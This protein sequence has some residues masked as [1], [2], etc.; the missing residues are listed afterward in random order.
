VLDAWLRA[1]MA[2]WDEAVGV[3]AATDFY[4]VQG[5]RRGNE[6]LLA[7]EREE[8]GPHVADGTTLLHLQCHFGL[9]TLSWARRGAEVVGVDFSEKGIELARRLADEIGLSARARFVRAEVY[10]LPQVLDRSFDVVFTSWGVLNWLGDLRRWARVASSFV[11]PGGLFYLVEFHPFVLMLD[12][13]EGQ[14]ALR[15]GYPYFHGAEPLRFDEPGSYADP[16]ATVEHTVTYEWIHPLG[17]IVTAL[18]EAGLEIEHLHE[19]P[20]TRG[21]A[22]PFLETRDDGW[23]HVRG[24]PDDVPLSFSV[25]A[26]RPVGHGSVA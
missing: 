23:Q 21:L 15:P 10:D 22:F 11:R 26:R 7:V 17:E 13:R 6:T 20:Y 2:W 9:D 5:F 16:A 24:R 14:T 8:L 3:H 12:D 19:F 4:D 1:N 18:L 25:M